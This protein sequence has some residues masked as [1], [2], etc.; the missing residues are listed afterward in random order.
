MNTNGIKAH[1]SAET[2]DSNAFILDDDA[3]TVMKL[4]NQVFLSKKRQTLTPQ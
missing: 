3:A 1:A 4:R 2:T